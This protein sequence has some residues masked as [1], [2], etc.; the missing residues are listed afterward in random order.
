MQTCSDLN[1]ILEAVESWRDLFILKVALRIFFFLMVL[2][3]LAV[4]ISQWG[5]LFLP[6]SVQNRNSN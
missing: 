2:E 4:Y 6:P 3:Q 5:K 1:R